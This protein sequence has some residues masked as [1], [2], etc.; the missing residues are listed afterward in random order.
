M[1]NENDAAFGAT[2]RYQDGI[3]AQLPGLTKREYFAAV[4][5]QGLLAVDELVIYTPPATV[6]R[7]IVACNAVSYADELIAELNKTND[8]DTD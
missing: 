6:H 2:V 4:A 5:M 1:T 3:D 8:K 7:E